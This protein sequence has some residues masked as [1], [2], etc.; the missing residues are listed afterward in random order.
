MNRKNINPIPSLIR[1]I[2]SLTGKWIV[3]GRQ[4]VRKQIP[5]ILICHLDIKIGTNIELRDKKNSRMSLSKCFCTQVCPTN[6]NKDKRR[7]IDEYNKGRT[8]R[9]ARN[10]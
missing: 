2:Y 4:T 10:T 8:T 3:R 6:A 7:Y 1:E 5:I 9:L